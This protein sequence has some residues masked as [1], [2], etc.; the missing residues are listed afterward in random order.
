M[1]E[2]KAEAFQKSIDTFMAKADGEAARN[3]CN[4]LK[5]SCELLMKSIAKERNELNRIVQ[6]LNLN[7]HKPKVD[8]KLNDFV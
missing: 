5:A 6:N 2:R 7:Q 3:E 8:L 1:Q 4:M